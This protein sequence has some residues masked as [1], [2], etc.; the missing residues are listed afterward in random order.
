ME[1]EPVRLRMGM[2]EMTEWMVVVLEQWTPC[3]KPFV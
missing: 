3:W 2:V 1:Q